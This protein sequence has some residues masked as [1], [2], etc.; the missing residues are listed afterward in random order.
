MSSQG[1]TWRGTL[2]CLG[3]RRAA[4]RAPRRRLSINESQ[5]F[6]LAPRKLP[7][8]RLGPA[9]PGLSESA[10]LALAKV[11][12]DAHVRVQLH[13]GAPRSEIPLGEMSPWG[14]QT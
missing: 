13:A 10:L 2:S 6:Q 11:A 5:H 1:W 4:C 14:K 3:T 8:H 12:K 9:G 7:F